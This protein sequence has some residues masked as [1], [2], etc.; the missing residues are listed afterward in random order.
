MSGFFGVF[1]PGGNLDQVAFD[2]MKSAVHQDGCDELENYVDDHIAMGH[3]MLRV[4]PDSAYDKQPL[5]SE[6]GRYLLVGHFRLDYRDELGDKLGL[7]QKE[8]ELTPDSMLAMKSYQKWGKNCVNH[9]E[10]DW[11]FVLYD[12]IRPSLFVSRDKIGYSALFYC[13]IGNHFYFS[14][15]LDVLVAGLYQVEVDKVQLYL[16][17]LGRNYVT[18]G[19]TLFKGISFLH[20]SSSIVIDK[21]LNYVTTRIK[22]LTYTPKLNFKFERDYFFEFRSTFQITLKNKVLAK[23]DLGI[24]LS[25]GY[26]SFLIAKSSDLHLRQTGKNLYSFTRSPIEVT[27]KYVIVPDKDEFEVIRH[28]Q[29][30]FTHTIFHSSSYN[31]I[32]TSQFLSKSAYLNSFDP[33]VTANNYWIEGVFRSAEN[34]GLKNL[35]IGQFGN[36]SLSWDAPKIGIKDSFLSLFKS[37]VKILFTNTFRNKSVINSKKFLSH[38]QMFK[39]VLALLKQQQLFINSDSLRR[40]LISRNCFDLGARLYSL[41]SSSS[42][43]LVD[44]TADERFLKLSILIPKEMFNHPTTKKYI[45]KKT[46][47]DIVGESFLNNTTTNIS[48]ARNFKYKLSSDKNIKLIIKDILLNVNPTLQFKT[49]LIDTYLHKLE[50]DSGTFCKTDLEANELMRHLSILNF[51]NKKINFNYE[52]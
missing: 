14:S 18:K 43:N 25:G 47:G 9:L 36:Y 45:Y 22:F 11:A 30:D 44:P 7:T 15:D 52:K 50:K 48:Q 23:G 16:M 8:L 20:P 5:K 42:V 41:G 31:E 35:L 40:F 2:Q 46:F 13:K 17:S 19:K 21:Q 6:C 34:K 4:T 12:K 24:F 29:K 28:L 51:C 37:Y 38:I 33:I 27:S 1:S 39:V 3:L 49:D 26:D 32:N 10:G